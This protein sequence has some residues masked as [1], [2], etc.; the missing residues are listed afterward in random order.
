MISLQDLREYLDALYPLEGYTDFGPSGLQLEGKGKIGK[1]AT[2]VSA[3]IDVIDA[4]RDFGADALIVHHGLFSN[5]RETRIVGSMHRKLKA[6]I[7]A[8]ISLFGYHLPMDAHPE[9]GNNWRAA[10]DLGIQELEPFGKL[11]GVD[12]GVKGRIAPTGIE[13]WVA[14]LEKY[15]GHKAH[16]ALGGPQEV[17]RVALLSGGGTSFFGEAIEAGVD[18]FVTGSFD[19]PQWHM[20]HEEGIHYV[21]LG[22]HATERVGPRALADALAKRF[23]V[24]TRFMDSENPF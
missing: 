22:H 10:H 2:G 3:S 11:F 13:D 19:E 20:A 5:K 21:A 1:I 4:A 12:F 15:Y 23:S 17:K 8:E 14:K 9:I 24:E 7:D 16:A 6:L 18:C